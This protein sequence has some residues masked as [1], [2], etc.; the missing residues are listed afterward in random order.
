MTGRQAG[1]A[2]GAVWVL[3]AALLLS[4]C[5][6]GN[7]R[8]VR[9]MPV[10]IGPPYTVRGTTYVPAADPGYDMLG[11]ASWYGSESGNR[12]ANG[13][14]FRAK[15]VTGAHT[16]LP[17]PSYVEVTALDT[18]RT[19]V[20]RVNDRGPFAGRGRVIDLSRGAAEQL[21]IRAQGHAAVR[22]RI[23]DP[24][25]KDREKLRK[26]KAAPERPRVPERILANLRAQLQAS[27]P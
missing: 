9:D 24:P 4:A 6:G 22:V 23:V 8:P 15:W 10:K 14:Q 17:L 12:T 25:E 19:I 13:E 16:T 5:G 26:G 27:A 2:I 18:G 11:Y 20:V 21:G 7:Y 3:A 1:R